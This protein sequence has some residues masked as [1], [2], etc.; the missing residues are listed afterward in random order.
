MFRRQCINLVLLALIALSAVATASEAATDT[1]RHL[2]YVR[3]SCRWIEDA[4]AQGS[5]ASP[6]FRQLLDQIEASHTFVFVDP[7][8]CWFDSS[9]ACTFVGSTAPGGRFF[10]VR[11]TRVSAPWHLVSILAHEFQ[12]VVEILQHPEVVDAASLR[13]LYRRIGFSQSKSWNHE[14]WETAQAQRTQRTVVAETTEYRRQAHLM[15]RR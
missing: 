5:I 8:T 4:I 11:A 1:R 13:A 14:G 15:A 3:T 2:V 12:H 10:R 6:T 7:M 9:D